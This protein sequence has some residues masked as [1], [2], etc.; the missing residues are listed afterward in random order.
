MPLPSK[1]QKIIHPL[2]KRHHLRVSIK[3]DDLIH[4]IISGNKWRKLKHNLIQLKPD[5]KQGVISFGGAY[6]NH[7]H[8]LAYACFQEN[9]DCIGI[10][11]GEEHYQNNFTLRWA[12]HWGMKLKFVNRKTYRL[13]FEENYLMEL[14]KQFPGFVIIPEGGSNKL[15]LPGV[16]EVISELNNQCQFDT[17]MTPVGSGG[18]I[19]GLINADKNHHNILGIAVLKQGGSNKST[20]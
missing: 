1:L 2:F 8:A 3:R 17:L 20:E 19:A 6:S 16:G 4:P 15:A 12:Q 11:R 13:R 10:I 18:T 14:Q 9:I 5:K 7:I